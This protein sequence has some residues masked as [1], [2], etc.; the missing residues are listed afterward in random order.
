MNLA[1][2]KKPTVLI[3][4]NDHDRRVRLRKMCEENTPLAVASAANPVEALELLKKMDTPSFILLSTQPSSLMGYEDFLHHKARD[5]RLGGI[6]VV[7]LSMEILGKLPQG[8]MLEVKAPIS[9]P[10]LQS[11]VK[12]YARS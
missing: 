5:P 6:P 4:L 8:A 9:L 2:S 11:L 1:Q 12:R 7:L 3:V 10:D